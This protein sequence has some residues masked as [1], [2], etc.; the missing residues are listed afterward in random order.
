VFQGLYKYCA[1]SQPFFLA[2]VAIVIGLNLSKIRP[3]DACEECKT[4]SL[5]NI[6]SNIS[7]FFS[8]TVRNRLPLKLNQVP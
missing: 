1:Y 5:H 3:F 7:L 2:H 8:V 4:Y 6:V